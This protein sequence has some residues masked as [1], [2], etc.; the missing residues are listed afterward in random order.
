MKRILYLLLLLTAGHLAWGQDNIVT[1]V[2]SDQEGTPLEGVTVVEKGTNNGVFT[3]GKGQY[4]LTVSDGATVLFRLAGYAAQEIPV[5]SS[6][7]LNVTLKASSLD[8]VV[9]IGYGEKTR[10][11][12]TS[13]ISTVGSEVIERSQSM[14][15]EL[16]LQGRIPGVLVTQPGGDPNSRVSIQIQGIGSF[17]TN[18]PLIVVDGIP[19]TEFGSESQDAINPAAAGDLRGNQNILNLINPNDI[20][21]VSVLKD[22]SAAAIYGF[23]AANGVI[24]ITTKRGKIGKPTVRLNASRGVQ[25][26]PR[27][28]DMLNTQQFTDIYQEMY[29]NNP[30]AQDIPAEFDP[31]SPFYLGDS[32]T[33]DNQAVM[34]N[35][36]AVNENYHLSISGG[37]QS[38]NYSI[39]AGYTRIE[40]P[41]IANNQVR[42]TF[43]V[44][45]D[46]KVNDW[47]RFGETFRAGYTDGYNNRSGNLAAY[48][49]QTPPWQSYLDDEQPLGFAQSS[50]IR[51]DPSGPNWQFDTLSD[52]RAGFLYGPETEA[53]HLAKSNPIIGGRRFDLYRTIGSA[54]L[55]IE[56]IKGVKLRGQY[57]ADWYLNKRTTWAYPTQS[58]VYNITGT[59]NV[60]DSSGTYAD[61]GERHSQN[62]NQV[63]DI[64]LN[65]DQS[66]GQ[67]RVGFLAGYNEQQERYFLIAGS[68]NQILTAD[69]YEDLFDTQED[70]DNALETPRDYRPPF[71]LGGG[72]GPENNTISSLRY[73]NRYQGMVSRLSYSFA[74]KVFVD[75]SI[76]ADGSSKFAPGFRWGY[77]PAVSA[78]WRLSEEDFLANLT[79]VDELK[80]R[81]GWGQVGSNQVARPNEWRENF[82]TN[83]AYPLGPGAGGDANAGRGVFIPN[84]ASPEL[85]WEKAN[86]TN[87]AINGELFNRVVTFNLGYYNRVR[88]GVLQQV[89]LPY[90]VGNTQ[91]PTINIATTRNQGLQFE[92]SVAPRL[93]D[94]QLVIS[95]NLTTVHNRVLDIF[96]DSPFG[97]TGG[98]VEKGFS[99]FYLWGLQTDGIFQTQE[100][101]D[102]WLS[103]YDDPGNNNKA[104]GDIRFVDNLG[105]PTE[106]DQI[107]GRLVN[108]NPDSVIN[109]NDR[110]FL[111]KTIP[112]V[113][114]GLNIDLAWKGFDF[115]IFFQG[116]GD[117]QKV[118]GARRAGEQMAGLGN[119][120]L[121]TT[122]NRWTPENPSNVM[123]RAVAEDP[124]SNNRF[125][126]RWVEDAGFIRLRQMQLGYSFSPAVREVIGNARQLRLYVAGSNLATMTNWS[127]IDPENDFNP[128]PRIWSVGANLTF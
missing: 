107:A 75:A 50:L 12:I 120:F 112:G 117:Y 17:G 96:Q 71:G 67:H 31:N 58:L 86:T 84:F 27:T 101:L 34:T 45:S 113:Y 109:S 33:Y 56:P 53:N 83:P 41:L 81:A 24:L 26:L 38:S 22:A 61:L 51:Y 54:Y 25:N 60:P 95:G 100:E 2:V 46:H 98:R 49:F 6:R 119:N 59:A 57:S 64:T 106:E 16:A 124:G 77:F 69:P 103:I 91:D 55:E 128:I 122:L 125:S 114:G 80:V 3:D 70:L 18:Q 21:S 7:S 20:E 68:S 94:L 10:R 5:S 63:L 90:V 110:V 4:R 36:N 8:E 73:N 74:D 19:I 15:T 11:A 40:A 126:D 102:N 88:E 123:P 108:P 79:W 105:N 118:N 32:P 92:V 29:A 52:G 99:M 66:F 97:G 93:G 65:V 89:S 14:Q 39:N 85:T 87:I 1:G 78:A 82:T 30:N 37:N 104:P 43:G 115:N 47:I 76:R 127:G 35:E 42:Y 72:D 44:N 28:F 23:R 9:V 48:A 111:G 121:T 13:D 62:L 116:V